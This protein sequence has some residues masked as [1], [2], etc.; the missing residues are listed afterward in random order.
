MDYGVKNQET[1][2]SDSR[3]HS[4]WFSNQGVI[5][6][7][8]N[9]LLSNVFQHAW[10][11][12]SASVLLFCRQSQQKTAS[13]FILCP[14]D[15]CFQHADNTA[16]VIVGSQSVKLFSFPNGRGLR[17]SG[18]L[19]RIDVCAQEQCFLSFGGMVQKY[20]VLH[21]DHY[22]LSLQPL[23]FKVRTDYLSQKGAPGFLP[24]GGS[25]DG[26]HFFQQG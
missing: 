22:D 13:V 16:T 24:S 15:E 14:E 17:M 2:F 5:R 6:H 9:F 8:D 3:F 7:G 21:A 18:R 20:I 23:V 26:N 12:S 1:L 25:W 4:G 19:D 11:S 10:K